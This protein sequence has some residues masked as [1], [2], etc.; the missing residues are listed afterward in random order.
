MISQNSIYNRIYQHQEG[1]CFYCK[2]EIEIYNMEKEH[3]FPRSK[4]GKGISNKVLSCKYCN[5]LKQDL[6]ILDFKNKLEILLQNEKN[7]KRLLRFQNILN[8]LNNLLNEI[9]RAHV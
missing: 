6:T 9:G 4:G 2:S 8:T 3:V 1:K 7:E 5:R